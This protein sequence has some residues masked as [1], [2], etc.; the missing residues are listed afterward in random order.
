MTA[1]S[2][3]P[4]LAGRVALVTGANQGIGAA[5][6][7]CLAGAG[8]TVL[9]AYRRLDQ[10]RDPAVPATY[11]EQRAS[12]ADGVVAAIRDAGGRAESCEADLADPD[13]AP[14]LFDEAAARFGPVEVLVNNA[15]AWHGDSFAPQ[16]LDRLG[17]RGAP[18]APEGIGASFAVDAV[19]AALLIAEFSRRHLERHA[20]WGRIIGLTSSGR[21]GFPGEVTYGAAKAAQESFTMSAARELA[22]F[23]VTANVV[24]PPVT[25]TGWI[26]DELAA[27]LGPSGSDIAGPDEVAAV[28]AFLASDLAARVTGNVIRLH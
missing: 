9:L 22:P 26:T 10:E 11:Y 5:I 1:T 14:A 2:G 19:A 25:D 24:H 27:A 7:R 18:V 21:H 4:G 12:D 16:R 17:R 23:G 15:S 8:A 6:A 28:V 13:S 20:G 3:L